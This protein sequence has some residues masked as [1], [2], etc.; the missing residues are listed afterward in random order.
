MIAHRLGDC[1]PA[2]HGDAF[3]S[4]RHIDAIA[5]NVLPFDNDIADIHADAEFN[6]RIRRHTAVPS[7]HSTLNVR[8]ASNGADNA[9]KFHEY[10]IAG[11]FDYSAV[12][13]GDFRV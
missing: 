11:E 5:Q 3:Q 13:L 4:R 9:G 12:V 8:G 10:S 2:W 7:A 1:N 6:T